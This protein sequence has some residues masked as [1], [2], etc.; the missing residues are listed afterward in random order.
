MPPI[1]TSEGGEGAPPFRF[2]RPSLPSAPRK[3]VGF[4][5]HVISF[6]SPVLTSLSA[7]RRLT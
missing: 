2:R 4:C 6:F 1:S 5:Y 7:Y 3:H